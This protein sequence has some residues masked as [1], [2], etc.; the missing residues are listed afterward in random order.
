MSEIKENQ[1]I[2]DISM[3]TNGDIMSAI[4]LCLAN[5][6]SITDDLTAGDDFIEAETVYRDLEVIES[7]SNKRLAT[8]GYQEEANDEGIGAMTIGIDFYVT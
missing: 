1:S 4:D 6:W 3:E 7:F 2:L 8:G 5:G